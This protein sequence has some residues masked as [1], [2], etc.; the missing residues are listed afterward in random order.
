MNPHQAPSAS[1]KELFA[2]FWRN[3][4]LIIQLIKRDVLSRYRGSVMGLAW[5]FF[6]P[7]L[8]LTVYTF[9]F[10]V[11]F[12]TRW[13]C[14]GE[15]SSRCQNNSDGTGK[16][17]KTNCLKSEGFTP[18][19]LMQG[20]TLAVSIEKKGWAREFVRFTATAAT[21][22]RPTMLPFF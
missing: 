2:S 3:R 20:S 22:T 17:A 9:V 10:S 7:L 13:G 21:G 18:V 1:I 14:G 5:S 16:T 6:N 12:K 15:V 11:M 4:Q 19:L 8:M